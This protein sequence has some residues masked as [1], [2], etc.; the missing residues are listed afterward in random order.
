MIRVPEAKQL[1]I[2]HA[3][4][5]QVILPVHKGQAEPMFGVYSK[6]CFT[7]WHALILQGILKLHQMVARFDLPKLDTSGNPLFEYPLFVN[8]NTPDDFEKAFLKIQR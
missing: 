3:A 2:Q 8:I 4:Q 1:T 6:S 5:S 7:Q